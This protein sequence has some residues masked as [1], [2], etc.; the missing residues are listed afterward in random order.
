MRT[1]NKFSRTFLVDKWEEVGE[2]GLLRKDANY[3][4][5]NP[6]ADPLG[7]VHD[8]FEHVRMLNAS[9]EMY[10]HGIMCWIRGVGEDAL[11]AELQNMCLAIDWYGAEILTPKNPIEINHGFDLEGVFEG[12]LQHIED[13]QLETLDHIKQVYNQWFSLGWNYAQNHYGAWGNSHVHYMMDETKKAISPIL[14]ELEMIT[15]V[16]ITV[17]IENHEVLVKKYE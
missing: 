8:M 10:A 15:R 12:A 3:E 9:D 7:I 5:Y 1:L 14:D 11:S 16:K 13:E 6:L 2:L 4:I 17:D